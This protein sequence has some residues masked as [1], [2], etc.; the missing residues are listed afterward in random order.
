MDSKP[1]N[2]L[3]KDR[4]DTDRLRWALWFAQEDIGKWRD[5]DWL[6]A[7]EDTGD[8]LFGGLEVPW[9]RHELSSAL[10]EKSVERAKNRLRP[11]QAALKDFLERLY[12]GQ[13]ADV[14]FKGRRVFRLGAEGLGYVDEP[15]GRRVKEGFIHEV[16]LRVGDFLTRTDPS[17]LK[18]CPKCNRLFLAVRRQVFDTPECALSDRM[19][20][21]REKQRQAE[22]MRKRRKK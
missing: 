11:L 15:S 9:P 1:K 6:N 19:E 12:K 22:R 18:R 5:G 13:P 16:L 20:R 10:K 8:L 7:L 21:F 4:T 14:S 17:R 3:Q 2:Q